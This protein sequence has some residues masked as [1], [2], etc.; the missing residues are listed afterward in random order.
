MPRARTY[1]QISEAHMDAEIAVFKRG[2]DR[3]SLNP[4][5]ETTYDWNLGARAATGP[6]LC[7]RLY[8]SVVPAAG[9]ARA[10]G[11]DAIRV[12]VVASPGT[13]GERLL[14]TLKRVHRTAG[15]AERMCQRLTDA[16]LLVRR[17]PPCPA[18][19]G[20]TIPRAVKPKDNEGRPDRKAP[21]KRF[22]WGCTSTNCCGA[23]SAT[24]VPDGKGGL[25][26]PKTLDE[27]LAG[28]APA[29]P[30]VTR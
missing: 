26:P 10:C 23:A 7:V 16:W 24:K 13:R 29:K 3:R 21:A 1:E 30:E 28:L 25:R 11:E 15:W 17:S 8:S 6:K 12:A 2:P 5:Q 19:G 22:F 9:E 4:N 14:L 20:Y 18:C 27:V